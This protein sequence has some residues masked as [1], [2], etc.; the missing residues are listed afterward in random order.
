MERDERFNLHLSFTSFFAVMEISVLVAAVKATLYLG[1]FFKL[2]IISVK[3]FQ[4]YFFLVLTFCSP[5]IF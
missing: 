3:C 2:Q 1:L 5:E 4:I